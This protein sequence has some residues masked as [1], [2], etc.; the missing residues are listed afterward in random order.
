LDPLHLFCSCLWQ[1][2]ITNLGED[3]G[4]FAALGTS[5][6]DSNEIW[7]F[8][9]VPTTSGSFEE[10]VFPIGQADPNAAVIATTYECI[11]CVASPASK[12]KTSVSDIALN[13]DLYD[14]QFSFKSRSNLDE[15]FPSPLSFYGGSPFS[16]SLSNEE[17]S[18]SE[19]D[20][21]PNI[22]K[23]RLSPA[24]ACLKPLK[25]SKKNKFSCHP[26]NKT[27]GLKKDL[28]RHLQS[29]CGRRK[30]DLPEWLCDRCGNRFSRKDSLTRHSVSE[31]RC[32]GLRNM[33]SRRSVLV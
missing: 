27:F 16:F 15:S 20:K 8:L 25:Q 17:R 18:S 11:C 22:R 19:D 10:S 1:A 3:L 6:V 4:I 7:S 32:S 31:S 30:L 12:V 14:S 33:E 24:P 21:P 5:S 28:T 9:D 26:C 2:D 13:S 29:A 23:R